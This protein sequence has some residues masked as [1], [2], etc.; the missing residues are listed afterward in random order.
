MEF[1]FDFN[2]L[3]KEEEEEEEDRNKTMVENVLVSSFDQPKWQ[4]EL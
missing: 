1:F 3:K 4:C 2:K